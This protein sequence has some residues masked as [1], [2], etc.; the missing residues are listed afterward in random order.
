MHSRATTLLL[1]T[2]LAC[3]TSACEVKTG[4]KWDHP[5]VLATDVTPS[6]IDGQWEGSWQSYES[7]D[8][9][10][11]HFVITPSEISP[12][13]ATLPAAASPPRPGTRRYLAKVTLWHWNVLNLC[14]ENFNMVLIATNGDNGQIQFHGDRD[15]GPL[16]GFSKYDGFIDANKAVLSYVNQDDFG[17]LVLR[18]VVNAP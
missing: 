10:L 5:V 14:K 3:L 4:D 9:G 15:L 2:T 8:S 18:R 7:W 17:S 1:A 12:V 11:I 16:E 13:P 6:A